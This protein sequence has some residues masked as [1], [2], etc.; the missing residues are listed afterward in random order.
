MIENKKS[1]LIL[2]K[3]RK[4]E[5]PNSFFYERKF[6]REYNTSIIYISDYLYK[7]NHAIAKT[8]NTIIE[9]KKISIVLFE[10]DHISIFDSKF[11]K[12]ISNK[13]KKGLFLL[14]DYMYHYINRITATACDFVLSGCPLSVL[15]FQELGYKSFF[16]PVETDGAI[17]KD[18][19]EK[20]VHD[21]LFF[22]RVK[23]NRKKITEYLKEN[24]V[25]I[26][27]C[28]PYDSISDTPEKLAR[29]INKS[30]IVLNFTE[31]DNTIK[32]NNPISHFKYSYEMKGR[33]YFT[34]LCNTLCISEYSPPNELLFSN[35]EVPFFFNEVECLSL[36]RDFLSNDS[37]LVNATNKYRQKC[38]TFEDS[39]YIKKVKTFI[40]YNKNENF[41]VNIPIWYEFIFFKKN[42]MLRF[43]SNKLK[44]F[45]S[46]VFDSVILTKYRYKILIPLFLIYSIFS[47]II[48]L[49]KFPI[50]KLKI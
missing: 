45:F 47:S 11:I 24:R 2:F 27:E 23:N 16:L 34:G 13:V 12:L 10:G 28:G 44:S 4:K 38:S 15:K 8:I 41:S 18:Y 37:K 46:Q 50:A 20:K 31:S 29:L 26:I 36:I 49:L 14:D 33:V 48:F 19:G 7:N 35:N 32:K 6:S 17:F 40:D 25:N 9:E 30:K 3:E 22:G 43:R 39:N 21:V 42:L 5:T 1:I